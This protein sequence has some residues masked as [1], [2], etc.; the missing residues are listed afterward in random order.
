MVI[1]IESENNTISSFSSVE[2]I[3]VQVD[4]RIELV[5]LIDGAAINDGWNGVKENDGDIISLNTTFAPDDFAV[6]KSIWANRKTC[7]V[8]LG[9]EV[10]ENCHVIIKSYSYLDKFESYKNVS[11][12]I[13]RV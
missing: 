12:E 3:N 9:D 2:N 8:T 4:D 5:K 6:L 10:I 1:K 13:W 11:L 7:K